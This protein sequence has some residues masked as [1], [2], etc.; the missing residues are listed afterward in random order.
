MMEQVTVTV[1]VDKDIYETIERLAEGSRRSLAEEVQYILGQAA[2]G[3][4]V[5]PRPGIRKIGF[6]EYVRN[7]VEA[8]EEI[9]AQADGAA[10]D[11]RTHGGPRSVHDQ[12]R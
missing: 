1:G 4:P 9:P 5:D 7:R 10:V 8:F 12:H 11:A 2:V 3:Q 6:V